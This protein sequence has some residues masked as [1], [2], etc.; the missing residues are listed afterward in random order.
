M[1][2]LIFLWVVIG[3]NRGYKEKSHT[4]LFLLSGA[5]I[6]TALILVFAIATGRLS[7]DNKE[8]TLY[9]PQA[10][11]DMGNGYTYASSPFT[12]AYN[13]DVPTV[14]FEQD[15]T[16]EQMP[17]P[18]SWSTAQLLTFVTSA[19]NKTQ[20]YTGD[21]SVIH[22]ESFVADVTECT[23]GS[24]V[25]GIAESMIG[26]VV[27]PVQE[28]LFYQNGKATN[29]EGETIPIMLPQRNSFSLS[30]G[31]IKSASIKFS[32]TDYV[33]KIALIEE[34]V[35]MYEKPVHNASAVGYLD[36]AGFD[37]SFMEIDSADIIYK[38]TTIELR[39]NTD[40]YVTYAKYNI[41]LKITGSAHKGIISGSA[42]FEGEQTE[43]WFVM[44]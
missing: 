17:D 15:Y 11:K 20:A 27:E 42:T 3:T 10:Y 44:G 29:S 4:S 40:G 12:D 26:W 18:S 21:L 22:S 36:V 30:I 38:G 39:I 1:L 37:L 14:T 16:T 13:P 35:G 43:E 34:R 41:P 8:S 19:V 23:G 9:I 2:L 24:V 25:E 32:G 6:I 33:V 28:T 7:F 5:F 31:G